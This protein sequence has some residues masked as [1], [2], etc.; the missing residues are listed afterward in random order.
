MTDRRRLEFLKAVPASWDET[1]VIN[2]VPPKYITIARRS[3]NEWYVGSI[4]DWDARELD[5]PLT[6]LGSGTYDAEIY[7]DG[8]NAAAQPK[9]SVIEKRRVNAQT[10]LKLKLA[11]G[12]GSAMRIVPAE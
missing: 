3:G 6:F 12:G 10:V 8:P 2:G 7:A 9:D 5:V 4:T 1:R 11:P